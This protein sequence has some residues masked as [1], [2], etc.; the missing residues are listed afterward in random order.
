[1][2]LYFFA[3]VRQWTNCILLRWCCLGELLNGQIHYYSTVL[4]LSHSNG[5]RVWVEHTIAYWTS[6]SLCELS[7]REKSGNDRLEILTHVVVLVGWWGYYSIL[8][9]FCQ[10]NNA[11]IFE[12]YSLTREYRQCSSLIATMQK[13]KSGGIP[14]PRMWWTHRF[15]WRHCSQERGRS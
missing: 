11:I 14:L 12:K 8:F 5:S 15:H 3:I 10:A 6:S 1:M 7:A 9:W 13:H 2:L 4:N